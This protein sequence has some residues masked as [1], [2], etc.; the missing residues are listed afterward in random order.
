M[1]EWGGKFHPQDRLF[2]LMSRDGGNIVLL[3]PRV[4]YST[5][6]IYSVG[7]LENKG[8]SISDT[9]K[10]RGNCGRP[11]ETHQHSF[12]DPL[13]PHFPLEVRNPHPKLQSKITKTSAHTCCYYKMSCISILLYAD[14][15]LLIAPSITL[16]QQLVLRASALASSP[17][18]FSPDLRLG[19]IHFRLCRPN[20]VL[21]F[22][23]LCIIFYIMR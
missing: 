10:D 9:R 20:M 15:I 8:G 3:H 14:D 2:H 5:F 17:P 22:I 23:P 1:P 19:L 21:A 18:N 4:E 11:I 13:R 6:F 12:S 16:L 7:V